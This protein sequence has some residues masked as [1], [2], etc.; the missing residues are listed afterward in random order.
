MNFID[1]SSKVT[2]SPTI[3]TVFNGVG[4]SIADIEIPGKVAD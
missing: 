1:N 4:T 3:A 2:S